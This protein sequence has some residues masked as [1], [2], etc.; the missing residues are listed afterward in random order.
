MAASF[1]PQHSSPGDSEPG[2][3]ARILD[4]AERCFVRS[5]FHR[6]TMQDVAAEAG[7]SPGNLYRYFRSK[8]AL[9]TGL[10]ERDRTRVMRDMSGLDSAEDFMAAL[11]E[12]ARK[13]FVDEP[14]EKAILCLETWAEAT[15]NPVFATLTEGFDEA[16]QE[17]MT[18]LFRA[19]QERGVIAASVDPGALAMI[20]STLANVLFVRRAVLPS[21]DAEREVGIV[22]KVIEAACAGRIDIPT[23]PGREEADLAIERLPPGLEQRLSETRS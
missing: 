17:R 3:A 20:V 1:K 8:D 2:R 23:P 10:V 14:R 6:A 12:L 4:A 7:M 19:A 15:R 22:M 21:F 9:A 16:V 13:H 5:G 11:S 18:T